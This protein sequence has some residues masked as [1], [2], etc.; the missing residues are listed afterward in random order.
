MVLALPLA[1]PMGQVTWPLYHLGSPP[2]PTRSVFRIALS[3]SAFCTGSRWKKGPVVK[4]GKP[5]W[6]RPSHACPPPARP[7]APACLLSGS[8][9]ACVSPSP[10]SRRSPGA[11]GEVKGRVANAASRQV[12]QAGRCPPG[13]ENGLNAMRSRECSACSPL[14]E[15]HLRRRRVVTKPHARRVAEA[16]TDPASEKSQ[17]LWDLVSSAGRWATWGHS[18]GRHEEVGRKHSAAKSC[19]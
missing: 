14:P 3:V 1:G 13:S 19:P 18:G 6:W 15:R 12:R 2:T 5:F 8:L 17:A 9:R 4:K 10:P 7:S 16:E 11:G